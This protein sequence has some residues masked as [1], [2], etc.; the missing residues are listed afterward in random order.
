MARKAIQIEQKAREIKISAPVKETL[1]KILADK[2]EIKL[3]EVF[4][5][6]ELIK[7]RG[8]PLFGKTELTVEYKRI[9][10]G[11]DRKFNSLAQL[12]SN[13]IIP[14]GPFD[15]HSTIPVMIVAPISFNSIVL[16]LLSVG[17]PGRSFQSEILRNN[18]SEFRRMFENSLLNEGWEFY[19]RIVMINSLK[20]DLGLTFEL[21]AM[22]DEYTTLLKA[23]VE[24]ELL[25][26]QVVLSEVT[27]TIQN[28][29]I[30]LDK[31]NFLYNTIAENGKSLKAVIGLN[32]I[33]YFKEKFLKKGLK[34]REFH[35]NLLANSTLPF[36]FIGRVIR[37]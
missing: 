37:R 30:I 21:V 6:F 27:R 34:Q 5:I 14:P 24:N 13:I 19:S 10:Q 7:R 25:N 22:Y 36:K 4:G 15:S 9:V 18:S 12:S 20:K 8:E 29:K 3:D 32:S 31:E 17:Y 1:N 28:D 2:K 23:F 33:L 26:K 11:N 35:Q 16:K